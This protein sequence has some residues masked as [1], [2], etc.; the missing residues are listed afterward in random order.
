MIKNAHYSKEINTLVDHN[1]S[2]MLKDLSGIKSANVVKFKSNLY[3][4]QWVVGHNHEWNQI[5]ST[6]N[7][8]KSDKIN[9]ILKLTPNHSPINFNHNHKSPSTNSSP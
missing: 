4:L 7:R 5:D 2:L 9:P 3:R 6:V 1:G 8:N